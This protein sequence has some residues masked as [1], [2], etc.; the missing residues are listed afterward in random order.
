MGQIGDPQN[1]FLLRIKQHIHY[2]DSSVNFEEHLDMLLL[3]EM[4][5]TNV[6]VA[7]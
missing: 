4:R 3:T 6:D 5:Q 2:Y 7:L 1:V